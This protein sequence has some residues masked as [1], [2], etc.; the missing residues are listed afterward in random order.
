MTNMTVAEEVMK[1]VFRPAM[2]S[3][4]SSKILVLETAG[5]KPRCEIVEGSIGNGLN[6]RGTRSIP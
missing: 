2:C 3:R 6:A 4:R 1:R 5:L